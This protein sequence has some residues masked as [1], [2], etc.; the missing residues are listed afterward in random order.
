MKIVAIGSSLRKSSCTTGML[1]SMKKNLPIGNTMDIIV[2]SDLP[3]FNQDLET[4]ELMPKS[5][6]EFRARLN[7]A[8]CI[9]FSLCEYNSSV[10][11][12]LK[13]A[14][15]WGSR[16]EY[17]NI[18]NNKPGG[19]V[20]AGGTFGG[21]RAQSHFRDIAHGINLRLYNYPVVNTNI[22]LTPSPFDLKTG[23]VTSEVLE[24]ELKKSISA[25]IEW[26][27]KFNTA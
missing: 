6:I 20:S 1:R 2:P 4:P 22:F 19:V 18:F 17:G 7:N 8:N 11:P 14:V 26:S 9:L 10:S 3:L 13:N 21:Y 15:D 25:L 16:G 23:D 24:D 12:A 27:K 5:V